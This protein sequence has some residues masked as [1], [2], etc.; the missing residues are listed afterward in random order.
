MT[1]IIQFPQISSENIGYDISNGNGDAV[2]DK[3]L[4]FIVGFDEGS[5]DSVFMAVNGE[6][7]HTDRKR[8]AEFLWCAAYMVDSEQRFAGG[9]Y[10]ARNYE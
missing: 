1:N 6:G 4:E 9:E 7:M 8:L 5:F 3:E 10:P 2:M